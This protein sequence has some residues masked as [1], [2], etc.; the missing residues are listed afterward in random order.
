MLR[1]KI[2]IKKIRN[3]FILL[4]AIIIM[5]GV[6]ANI[7]NSRAENVIQVEMEVADKNNAL[8]VQTIEVE[9]TET[10]DGNY[11]LELPISVNEYVVSKYYTTD[12]AEVEMEDTEADK[13][14]R[15][16]ETEV[17]NKKV[18]LQTDYKTKEVTTE[19]NQKVTLYDKEMKNNEEGEVIVSGYVPVDAKVEV[20]EIDKSA[21]T[22]ITL[23]KEEQ[24]VQK[25]YEVSVYQE[26]AKTETSETKEQS[27]TETAAQES[28]QAGTAV[29]A[30]QE[31]E[32]VEYD[33]SKYGE[34]L[35]IKTKNTT[36][37]TKGT[38]YTLTEDNQIKGEATEGDSEYIEDAEVEKTD[39]T[40][41]YMLAT[42]NI[43]QTENPVDD[44]NADG[45]NTTIDSDENTTNDI[46]VRSTG[47][48][49]MRATPSETSATSGF[50]GNTTIQR[51]NIEQV[52]FID[53]DDLKRV[54]RWD[55][56][57]NTGF[58]HSG[59]T[60]IWRDLVG[61]NHG[62]INGGATFGSD[63]LQLDGYDDWVSLGQINYTDMVTLDAIVMFDEVPTSS[64]MVIEKGILGNPESGGYYL[65]LRN[66]LPSFTVYIKELGDYGGATGTTPINAGQKVRI[67]GTYDGTKACLY[68]NGSL[69]AS[70]AQTGTIGTPE[71]NTVVAIGCN[72]TGNSDGWISTG[73]DNAHAK[74][75]VYSAGVYH[76]ALLPENLKDFNPGLTTIP[77][78]S[79]YDVSKNASSS[80]L[81]DL[82]GVN[83]GKINGATLQNG[84][85]QFDGVNDWVN[86]GEMN[87]TDKVTLDATISMQSLKSGEVT[88]LGNPEGGGIN[89]VLQDGKPG[90]TLYNETAGKWIGAYASTALTAGIKTRI[91]VT[92]D[93]TVLCLYINGTLVK[94]NASAGKIKKPANNT[95]M[96]IGA[97]PT[98]TRAT[99]GWANINLYSANIYNDALWDVSANN[100]NSIVAWATQNNSNG[101]LK[102]NVASYNTIYANTNASYLFANIGYSSICTET[103][104]LKNLNALHTAGVT[105][106]ECMFS[107][108]GYVA[109]TT[110]DIGSNFDTSSVLNMSYMFR[111][112]RT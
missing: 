56:Y 95:V 7:R 31:I 101:A 106:M 63:Y 104:T 42:E 8:E 55:G 49:R 51:Q 16:T 86:L 62:S 76:K 19:D 41:K 65:Q 34:T 11:L 109:M 30:E 18:Q 87:F 91:T 43:E 111:D 77:H 100:D 47:M 68:V 24:T 50:L 102:V 40:V 45:E 23:P 94:T 108:T 1:N 82:V 85:L 10:K 79:S 80:T 66:G 88:V 39:K 3:I 98:G 60:T 105:N 107:S 9:A 26:V 5:L 37:N 112:M 15:L 69:V 27:E 70:T 81:T 35:N 53:P 78:V 97:N 6:Y 13:T 92:Y 12:D 2:I 103:T 20:T 110:F 74:M 72:P 71:K 54:N 17:A 36:E 48:N 58:G 52:E 73:E 64:T 44:E 57:N 21:L 75:K 84:Y 96:A 89:L 67:T 46:A 93:G 22:N 4:M 33:A 32:K 14:L 61:S 29:P 83:N 25:G 99:A 90:V 28:T 59:N 38:I